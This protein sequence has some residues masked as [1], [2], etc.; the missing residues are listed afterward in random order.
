MFAQRL[1]RRRSRKTSM[2]CVT[3]L[4]AG[5]SQ[6][7]GEFPAQTASNAEN[8]S[9]WCRHHAC[10]NLAHVPNCIRILSLVFKPKQD[11]FFTRFGQWA[12]KSFV[13]WISICGV[14]GTYQK[15]TDSMMPSS[16]STL[17]V[18]YAGNLPVTGEFPAQ[19]PVTRS[20]H[21]FF[22]LRLNKRLSK[23]SSGWWFE[24][25]S[26]PLWRQCN[27]MG[28]VFK[29]KWLHQNYMVA[30]SHCRYKNKRQ[31]SIVTNLDYY[32]NM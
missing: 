19:R 5:N 17:L 16:L 11:S 13:I 29:P 24:T 21:V 7:T 4:C 31:R 8:F 6:V 18:I 26:C 10:C 1:F 23:Q 28:L 9:I 32:I 12:H 30:Y 27:E 25:P 20:F 14:W 3:G 22:D 15:T 2:L